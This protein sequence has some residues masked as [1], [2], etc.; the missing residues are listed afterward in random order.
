MHCFKKLCVS[1]IVR[2]ITE[3][4]RETLDWLNGIQESI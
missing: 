4:S 1:A 2:V 3:V